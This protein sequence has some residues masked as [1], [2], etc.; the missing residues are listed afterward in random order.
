MKSNFIWPIKGR[1]HTGH[2]WDTKPCPRLNSTFNRMVPVPLLLQPKRTMAVVPSYPPGWEGGSDSLIT[3][4]LKQVQEQGG[5]E[6]DPVATFLGA[7]EGFPRVYTFNDS[8]KRYTWRRDTERYRRQ[9]QYRKRRRRES[10]KRRRRV[11]AEEGREVGHL[12]VGKN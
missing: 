9:R 8:A 11:G 12:G 1:R 7:N 3:S 4:V 5:I 6:T 10:G 2:S